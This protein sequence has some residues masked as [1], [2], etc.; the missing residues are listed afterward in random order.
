MDT[1]SRTA[2]PSRRQYQKAADAV[3]NAMKCLEEDAPDETISICSEAL[4][5]DPGHIGAY[6]LRASCHLRKG[7]LDQAIADC[8]TVIQGD[9]NNSTAYGVKATAH[10][11]KGD[12]EKAKADFAKWQGSPADQG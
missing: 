5:F 1:E 8:S 11:G 6:L 3:S 9:P 7:D 12:A 2:L 10:L 4:R